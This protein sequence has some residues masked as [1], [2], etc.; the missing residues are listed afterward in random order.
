[1]AGVGTTVF[2]LAIV[3]VG[4]NGNLVIELEQYCRVDL[5]PAQ[6]THGSTERPKEQIGAEADSKHLAL[7]LTLT[8]SSTLT[9]LSRYEAREAAGHSFARRCKK[10]PGPFS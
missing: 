3:G 9:A 6:A 5:L 4:K 7:S 2:Q 1:M 10:L 8:S